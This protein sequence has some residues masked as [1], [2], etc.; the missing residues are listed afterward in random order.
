[1]EDADSV[2]VFAFRLPSESHACLPLPKFA[3][4]SQI[5]LIRL[6][7]LGTRSRVPHIQRS[8]P[9]DGQNT[10]TPP[11]KLISADAV[12]QEIT[13]PQQFF[14]RIYRKNSP[15]HDSGFAANDAIYWP[16][17]SISSKLRGKN[18]RF[19]EIFFRNG[20][21]MTGNFLNQII[22]RNID[23]STNWRG[24]TAQW[25]FLTKNFNDLKPDLYI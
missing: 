5:H 22:P 23:C 16:D 2:P 15:I 7:T 19:D 8:P 14:F 1:M 20:L 4:T 24:T 9:T 11:P 13:R 3:I 18:V 6:S 25:N 21:W 10:L 17:D 12:P